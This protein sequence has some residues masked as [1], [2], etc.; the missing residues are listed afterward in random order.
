MGRTRKRKNYKEV[1]T[2]SLLLM[3]AL[4]SQ[5]L[6]AK[7]EEWHEHTRHGH[8]AAL[9]PKQNQIGRHR[10]LV[11][12]PAFERRPVFF[13]FTPPHCLK[14]NATP[15]CGTGRGYRHPLRGAIGRAPGPDSPPTIAQSMPASQSAQGAEKRF[16]REELDMG[17]R[18]AKVVDPEGI[19]L[20]L[21]ADAHPDL[22][23]HSRFAAQLREAAPTA[24]VRI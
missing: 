2:K 14:K 15:A 21:D 17:C 11:P 3:S 19:I 23:A 5:R 1:S 13:L 18:G 8:R 4:T 24:L 6:S 10:N 22:G 9:C 7:S 20:V 16:Q 12:R